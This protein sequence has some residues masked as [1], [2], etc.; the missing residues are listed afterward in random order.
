MPPVHGHLTLEFRDRQT[1][2]EFYEASRG[3]DMPIMNN[4]FRPVGTFSII[5]LK[6]PYIRARDDALSCIYRILGNYDP[7]CIDDQDSSRDKT[8]RLQARHYPN[9]RDDDGSG[10]SSFFLVDE[11]DE[12][13]LLVD[14][15]WQHFHNVCKI[16]E[17]QPGEYLSRSHHSSVVRH[18][19][20][21]I[22]RRAADEESM[23]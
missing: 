17:I 19:E 9:R 10:F 20:E 18:M 21:H 15:H 7:L 2:D 5:R 1:R 12:L 23:V 16:Q 6:P 14:V 22:D 11:T 13:T 8:P 3:K 4:L